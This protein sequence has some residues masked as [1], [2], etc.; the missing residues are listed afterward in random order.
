MR[1][2]PP[3]APSTRVRIRVRG[4]VQGV[5]FRPFVHRLALRHAVSGFVYNDA[6]GVVIE[7]EG[8]GAGRLIAALSTEAPPLSRVDAVEVADIPSLGDTGFA[9][10]ESRRGTAVATA[11]G[12][13]AAICRNC[14]AELFD[15]ADRRH[16]YPFINCTD[17]GPR[18]TIT[19]TLPYDRA[20]TSMAAFPLCEPCAAEYADPSSR[21]FHAEPNACPTC[22]PRL[23][24]SPAEIAR[25]LGA[26]E[27][28]AIKGLGGYHLAA[29]ARNEATVALLRARKHRDGK[30]FALM[31]QGL[32]AARRLVDIGEAEA[33]LLASTERPVVVAPALVAPTLAA[34]TLAA[35]SIAPS[36][37]NGL[38][39]LGV[40]LPYTPLHYLI[41]HALAGSPAGTAWIEAP[42]DIALVMTSA[43]VSGDPL[44]ID[45]AVA[46]RSLDGIADA[47]A[48]HDRAIVVRADDSVMRLIDAA[49]A[50]IRRA[51]GIVPRPI[52]L[53][54][55]A[56]PILAVGAF[57]KATICLTRGREAFVSQHIGDLDSPQTIEF[58]IET[59]NRMAD[60]LE[61]EPLAV[62]C[63][64]HPD[65]PSTR[66]AEGLGLP[67]HPV[68]H[69]VAHVASVVAEHG[70]DRPVIGLALDGYGRGPAGE[71]WGGELI[72]L[73][74]ADWRHL[75]GL[76]P[77]AQP[78]GDRAAEEPWRM[79]ASVLHGLGRGDEIAARFPD[80]P[81][82]A[83]LARLL[84][85]GGA[86]VMETT[87]MGRYF[88]A[89][90]ALA[91]LTSRHSYE[92][93]GPMRLEAMARAP[94]PLAG[95][96]AI[97]DGHLHLAP[98]LAAIADLPD[99]AAIADLWHGTLIEALADWVATAARATGTPD[100]AL[101]GGCFLNR[102]LCEGLA[103][104]LCRRGLTPHL[105]RA[106]PPN[107]GGLSLGQAHLAAMLMTR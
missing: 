25:R 106:L 5:G 103:A 57:L 51:R 31:V 99:A 41:F 27:I 64:L 60:F 48:S 63:D 88:D 44:V 100:I 6:E 70:I 72:H 49:P 93:E 50:F 78:G 77:I 45:D 55:E 96:Y 28:V 107:D 71:A 23:S 82:A 17:C 20:G 13:D 91:G 3:L 94:R 30:P 73:D 69:H 24:M 22:G 16:L 2:A 47:I 53:A 12:P 75:G 34:P 37:A 1:D 83:A 102:V 40:M 58:M 101:G 32:A 7:A 67:A 65:F 87:S 68:Q 104:G 92:G 66:I 105:P 15:P 42:S 84:A 39:T 97:V 80:E 36:V 43:N 81:Q 74:G 9:I 54:Y 79:A 4:L 35:N 85:H 26:G 90:A 14:L 46:V 95:G 62:A 33:A 38:S 59:I 56:P 19:R 61:I 10:V 89:A 8:E 86:L 52:R 11:I 21:R 76:A 18:L 29:D 98:L